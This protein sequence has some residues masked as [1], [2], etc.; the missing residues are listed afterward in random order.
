MPKNS[1]LVARRRRETGIA[2]EFHFGVGDHLGIPANAISSVRLTRA[3]ADRVSLW[4]HQHLAAPLPM[5][6]DE[7]KVE[8]TIA[9]Q[10]LQTLRLPV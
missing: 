3:E 4:P 7:R 1:K 2:A 8:S 6:D 9:W 5:A 10:L